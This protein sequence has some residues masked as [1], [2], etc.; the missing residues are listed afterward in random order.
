MALTLSEYTLCAGR[1]LDLDQFTHALSRIRSDHSFCSSIHQTNSKNVKYITMSASIDNRDMSVGDA[2]FHIQ[3][4]TTV[5]SHTFVAQ[6]DVGITCLDS[7]ELI[8]TSLRRYFNIDDR[9]I[10]RFSFVSGSV[11]ENLISEYPK[12]SFR[13]EPNIAHAV[14]GARF[15]RTLA[16][17]YCDR[18]ITP[19][20]AMLCLRKFH[21][22][23]SSPDIRN[24]G[25]ITTDTGM[26]TAE[27]F[28]SMR[29]GEYSAVISSESNLLIHSV[30]N[31][32]DMFRVIN[33]EG[34]TLFY[35]QIQSPEQLSTIAHCTGTIHAWK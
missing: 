19:I 35:G 11:Y 31:A 30:V 9:T 12:A 32:V 21:A 18:D 16:G 22:D 14:L 1:G 17:T 7:S 25:Q 24:I 13:K 28:S 4:E 3:S 8:E 6:S 26:P 34:I 20:I 29:K 33:A 27:A 23:V 15:V 5:D 10:V 2:A